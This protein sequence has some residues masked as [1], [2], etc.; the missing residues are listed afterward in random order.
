MDLPG[1]ETTVQSI[2]RDASP[3]L[4]ATKMAREPVD[5]ARPDDSLRST[6]TTATTTPVAPSVTRH[7][8]S[9]A[10]KQVHSRSGLVASA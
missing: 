2:N 5:K 3:H 7:I 4:E 10:L 1:C 6:T 9:P 8:E